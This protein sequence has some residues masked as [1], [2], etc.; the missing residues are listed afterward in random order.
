MTATRQRRFVIV[1]VLAAVLASGCNILSVPFFLFG[2]EPKIEPLLKKVASD[3]KDTEVK[4]VVVPSLGT[5]DMRTELLRADRDIAKLTCLFLKKGFEYNKEWVTVVPAGKVESF[6]ENHPDWKTMGAAEI[7]R[8]FD[9]DYVVY[10]EINELSLFENRSAN[11]LYRGKANITIKLIDANDPEADHE[12]TELS[13]TYPGEA[14]GP[15]PV[16]DKA[17]A[18]FKME[19]FGH[20]ARQISWHFTS[21]TTSDDFGR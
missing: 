21:H 16:E 1:L 7:G 15:I 9:A 5:L 10:L 20:V 4:I 19:F 18:A 6:K 11:H 17:P 13:C 14:R 3:D 8:H 2:P 12:E